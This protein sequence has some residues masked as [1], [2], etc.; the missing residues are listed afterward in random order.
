MWDSWE[1]EAS[2]SS[3]YEAWDS[4]EY[5]A[6]KSSEYEYEAWDSSENETWQRVA[7]MRTA[8]GWRVA[9]EH[10]LLLSLARQTPTYTGLDQG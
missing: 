6:W 3:E 5:E 1:Y 7:S 8:K 4:S 10:I 2:D 9:L